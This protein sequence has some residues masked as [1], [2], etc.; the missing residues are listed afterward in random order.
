ME[1]GISV[2]Q[3]L[4]C[5][6]DRASTNE[7][8]IRAIKVLYPNVLDIRC[9]SH[10]IDNAGGHFRTPTLV[11]FIKLWIS[12]FSHSPRCRLLWKEL[13]GKSMASFSE[14]RWW[15][16]WEVCNQVFLSV[17]RCASHPEMSPA[18]TAKLSLLLIDFQKKAYLQV[19]LAALVDCGESFVKATYN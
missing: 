15:S 3:V 1:Y 11:E 6:R 5:M 8:A 17:Q 16:R 14:T 18:T 12:L 9:F 19:E 7:V 10:T 13:T 4:A 2:D